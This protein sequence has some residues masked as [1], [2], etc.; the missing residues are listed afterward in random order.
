MSSMVGTPSSFVNQERDKALA[1]IRS[2]GAIHCDSEW[3]DML[4]HDLSGHLVVVDLEDV[5]WLKSPWALG[6]ISDSTQRT[7]CVGATK[8]KL[9]FGKVEYKQYGSIS[10]L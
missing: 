2:C 6:R 1:E 3:R 10:S 9:G 8:Y 7:R 4:W 5:K